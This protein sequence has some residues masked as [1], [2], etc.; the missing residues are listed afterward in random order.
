MGLFDI[1]VPN[2]SVGFTNLKA[3]EDGSPGHLIK[4]ALEGMWP[5][6]EPYADLDF[7]EAFA[8][9]EDPGF[10]E[11]YLALVLL[12]GRKKLRKRE[13][14]TKAQRDEGPDICIQKGRRNIWIEAMAP[15][16]GG[17]E[18]GETN[19]DRVPK[20]KEGLNEA[21][22]NPRRQ[23]ELR[24]TGA[25]RTKAKKFETYR[26]KGI[27]GEKD[28]C[29]VAVSGGQFMLEA[30][31]EFLPHVVS[32]VYSFGEEVTFLDPHTGNLRTHFKFSPEIEF[33][34]PA[35]PD[36]PPRENPKRTIFQSEDY[37]SISGLIWSLRSIGSFA[38]QPHDLMYVHNQAAERPIPRRWFDWADEY[39]PN[40]DGT[41][42]IRKQNQQK[43]RAAKKERA[44][45]RKLTRRRGQRR[46]FSE[47]DFLRG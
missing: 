12:E 36:E 2:A 21:K 13:E 30:V 8:I 16:R 3:S 25:L 14:L 26:E 40:H 32:A 37:K 29:I 38:G 33:K 24:I 7:Q 6:Y 9:D 11:M 19:P 20:L 44:E 23:I 41:Q 46:G 45:L 47:P 31:G 15:D 39:Y 43:R 4:T 42:L 10:W 27:I 18:P 28:S 22:D 34:K 17:E 35:K 1:D 5:D